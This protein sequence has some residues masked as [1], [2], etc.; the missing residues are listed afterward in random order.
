MTSASVTPGC[1]SPGP[2]RATR[3][4][5]RLLLGAR[6]Y[7]DGITNTGGQQQCQRCPR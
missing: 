2:T 1:R 7:Y 6:L 3:W 4:T 5:L